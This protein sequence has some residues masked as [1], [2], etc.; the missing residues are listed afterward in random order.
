VTAD[1]LF[2]GASTTKA[3]TAAAL[4]ILMASGNHS[5]LDWKTPVVQLIRDDFLL[6]DRARTESVTIE[7]ALSHRTGMPRRKISLIFDTN[8]KI[9]SLN[10]STVL[11]PTIK[12]TSLTV[13]SIRK[14]VNPIHQKIW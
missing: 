4:A 10:A 12:M 2:L 13:V 5:G 3:F 8:F 9:S 1:T 7:D 6:E 11:T 14:L